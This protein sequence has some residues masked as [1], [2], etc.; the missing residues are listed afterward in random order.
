MFSLNIRTKLTIQFTIIVGLIVGLLLFINYLAFLLSAEGEFKKRLQERLALTNSV[1]IKRTTYYERTYKALKKQF[2]STPIPGEV[3]QIYDKDKCISFVEETDLILIADTIIRR[4]ERMDSMFFKYENYTCYGKKEKFDKKE[5]VI[6]V[7]G[8]DTY[9]ERQLDKFKLNSIL[10]LI[11][12]TIISAFA[13]YFFASRA[14]KPMSDVV[15]QVQ[16]IS[17][18]NLSKR[19]EDKGKKDE[20][21]ELI[22][23][24]NEMLS[25]VEATFKSQRHFLSN[26]SH[27]LRT[28]LT[29]II[30]ELEVL[31]MKDREG[32]EY[33]KA[34]KKVYNEADQLKEMLNV[35][36]SIN[37]IENQQQGALIEYIRADELIF[38]MCQSLAFQKRIDKI[39]IDIPKLPDDENL[40]T[41]K[42]N[43]FLLNMVLKN[44]FENALKFS[45]NKPIKVTLLFD[46]YNILL[47]VCDQGIG[48]GEEDL[49]N[50]FQTFYRAENARIYKGTG[51]GL[52]LCQ[53]IV[54]L[55]K[56]EIT[57]NSQL[58]VGTEVVVTLPNC[59]EK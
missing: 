34:I 16:D 21:G 14:V 6:V 28:P 53:K 59:V 55:H 11:A 37:F 30:A 42:G 3:I 15:H 7:A 38:D 9:S 39:N 47:K 40:L 44:L 17:A 48:I 54:K 26:A 56:G 2:L 45:D 24:F 19:L 33:R 22:K 20:I 49:A 12:S 10:F 52:E 58:N 27:E 23:T 46:N 13:G 51:I 29:A 4:I 32:H 41:L 36:L 31:L 5:F 1:Y 25:R 43:R 8:I 57:I 50:L 35:L 18:T